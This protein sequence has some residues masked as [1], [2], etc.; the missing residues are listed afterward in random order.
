MKR[1][2][3]VTELPLWLMA[4][5]AAQALRSSSRAGG[6]GHFCHVPENVILFCR[7][8]VGYHMTI[9]KEPGCV[10]E[11]VEKLVCS[12]VPE[13]HQ[14]TDVGAELSFTLP[15]AAAGQFPDLFDKLDGM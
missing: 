9:V 7:Y 11:N 15:S 4:S 13:A 3:L 10:S 8:G 12:Y 6:C 14:E 2:F 5:S 1:I